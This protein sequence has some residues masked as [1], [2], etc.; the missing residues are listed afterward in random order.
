M[1]TQELGPKFEQLLDWDTGG[2]TPHVR[3]LRPDGTVRDEVSVTEPVHPGK[4][5]IEWM[6]P[7]PMHAIQTV[8]SPESAPTD[9]P[10]LRVEIKCRT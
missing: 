9:P 3:Y 7:E 8:E 2:K 5:S 10:L 4:W 6:K 1:T